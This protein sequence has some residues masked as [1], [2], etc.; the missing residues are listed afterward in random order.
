MLNEEFFLKALGKRID[1]LRKEKDM[2]FQDLAYKSEI[3]MS[4]LV[5]LLNE[6]SNITTLTLLKISKALNVSLS[7]IFDFDYEIIDDDRS[8]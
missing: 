2:S 7:K 5:K 4:C 3:E 6:G 1:E 8:V